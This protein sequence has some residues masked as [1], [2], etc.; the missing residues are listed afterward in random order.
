MHKYIHFLENTV[1][2]NVLKTNQSSQSCTTTY[3]YTDLQRWQRRFISV[4]T[5]LS[6]EFSIGHMR[7]QLNGQLTGLVVRFV[8]G[9]MSYSTKVV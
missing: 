2:D 1:V 5:M 9:G 6:A 3:N 7:H 4:V 8:G